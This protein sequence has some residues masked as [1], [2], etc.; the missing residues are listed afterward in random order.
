MQ[1]PDSPAQRPFDAAIAIV[2][3]VAARTAGNHA[4]AQRLSL[5]LDDLVRK[6]NALSE[7]HDDLAA[8]SWAGGYVDEKLAELEDLMPAMRQ[9]C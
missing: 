4:V 7:A 3:S 9:R 8:M 2:R 5:M 1:N 6:R